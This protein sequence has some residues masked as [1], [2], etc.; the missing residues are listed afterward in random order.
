[1]APTSWK[2]LKAT[3]CRLLNLRRVLVNFRDVSDAMTPVQIDAKIQELHTKYDALRVKEKAFYETQKLEPSPE[4]AKLYQQMGD[5][6]NEIKAFTELKAKKIVEANTD[7]SRSR[8]QRRCDLEE[9]A[10]SQRPLQLNRDLYLSFFLKFLF[11]PC[12][13]LPSVQRLNSAV[14]ASEA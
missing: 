2:L 13:S 11:T 14:H 12:D 3:L 9:S 4:L 1:M 8:W 7:L 6:D 5:I 10:G